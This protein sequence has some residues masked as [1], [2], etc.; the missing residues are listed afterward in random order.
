[1]HAEFSSPA[2]SF[3]AFSLRNCSLSCCVAFFSFAYI[4]SC[5]V[6]S[7]YFFLLSYSYLFCNLCPF[8]YFPLQFPFCLNWRITGTHSDGIL[9][10]QTP[11]PNFTLHLIFFFHKSFLF[12]SFPPLKQ[13][14]AFLNSP[15]GVKNKSLLYVFSAYK[16]LS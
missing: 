16:K 12:L 5:Y 10:L 15:A 11:V 9:Q 3:R 14:S 1:M 8:M 4:Q 13:N 6:T 7:L 2:L